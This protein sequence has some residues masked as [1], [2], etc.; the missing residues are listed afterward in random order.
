MGIKWSGISE[1][2]KHE[3]FYTIDSKEA[4]IKAEKKGLKVI[5]PEDNQLQIDIDDENQLA[6]FEERIKKLKTHNFE[7]KDVKIQ[8]SISGSPHRHIYIT[9]EEHFTDLERI[10]LQLFLGSDPVRELLSY[11]RI[12]EGDEYPTLFLEKEE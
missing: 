4:F 8:E 11:E 7:I 9:L 3:I 12:R 1:D 5:V 2:R 6:V 10:F